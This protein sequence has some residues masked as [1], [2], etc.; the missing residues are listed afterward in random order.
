[1]DI[2]KYVNYMQCS[3]ETSTHWKTV[4][5]LDSV[6]NGDLQKRLGFRIM[7]FHLFRPLKSLPRLFCKQV[8][9]QRVVQKQKQRRQDF[10][11]GV[12]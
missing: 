3:Y 1:M 11:N 5:I 7:V 4:G 9:H 10:F 12:S 8:L 2:Y 6:F